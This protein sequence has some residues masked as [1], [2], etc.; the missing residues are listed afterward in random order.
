MKRR[1]KKWNKEEKKDKFKHVLKVHGHSYHK[2]CC[3][4]QQ[5]PPLSSRAPRRHDEGS[6]LREA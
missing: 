1:R 5:T 2:L 6:L 4:E 3:C